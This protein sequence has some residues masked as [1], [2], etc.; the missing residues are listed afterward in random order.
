MHTI[1]S[2]SAAVYK[3]SSSNVCEA[4]SCIFGERPG[5]A[6]DDELVDHRDQRPDRFQSAGKIELVEAVQRL[7]PT[8]SRRLRNLARPTDCGITPPRY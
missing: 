3:V 2:V 8:C 1:R 7:S 4:G 5:T 6:F